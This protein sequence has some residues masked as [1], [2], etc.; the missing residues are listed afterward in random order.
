MANTLTNIMPKILARALLVLREQAIMPRLVNI[1]YGTEAK[2][3]GET[4]DIPKSVAQSAYNVSPSAYLSATDHSQ[5]LVQISLDNWKGSNFYL[6]D[7]EMAEIDSNAHFVPNQMAEAVRALSNAVNQDIHNEYRGIYGFAGT[8][9]TTPFASTVTGATDSRKILNQQ[10]APR[11]ERRGVLDYDAEANALALSPFS[12][13]EKIMGRE[14]K[15][16]G[17]IG[18]KFGIDWTADDHVV[19]HTKGTVASVQVASTTAAGS[20]SVGIKA[21][22]AT[23]TIVAGDIFTVAGNT[24]TYTATATATITSAGVDVAISP[25]LAAIASA[26]AVVT[27]K[28]SHVV[29]LVFHRDAF[30]FANRPLKDSDMGLGASRIMEMT[31]PQT[32]ISL[33]L[34]V[35]RQNKRTTWELDILWGAKLVDARKAMRLAG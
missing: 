32:G 19:T 21:K 5:G 14:V 13:A 30:A 17:E 33:R 28:D 26:N 23:G 11:T 31:D 15:I 1:D 29:N 7:K 35:T 18:R 25:G 20:S 22:G 34:E 16:E 9:G 8:A 24:Q 4:I 2:Q 10:L 6:T 27:V 12:D 3:K